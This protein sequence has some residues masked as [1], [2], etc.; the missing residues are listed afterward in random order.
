MQT[1]TVDESQMHEMDESCLPIFAWLCVL[2]EDTKQR[3][4][5]H[6]SEVVINNLSQANAE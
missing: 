3:L 5:N 6:F 2:R 4:V 1:I